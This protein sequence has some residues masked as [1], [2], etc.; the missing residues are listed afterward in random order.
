MPWSINLHSLFNFQRNIFLMLR[1]FIQLHLCAA[2]KVWNPGKI[3]IWFGRHRKLNL[4]ACNENDQL[5]RCRNVSA[6]CSTRGCEIFIVYYIFRI[7]NF[8]KIEPMLN[9]DNTAERILIFH[10]HYKLYKIFS[11]QFRLFYGYIPTMY[12]T[13]KVNSNL[14]R[15]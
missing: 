7:C 9:T 14:L 3:N 10:F 5:N 6:S 2:L 15:Y 8:N 1:F 11:L 4:F 12:D 13:C